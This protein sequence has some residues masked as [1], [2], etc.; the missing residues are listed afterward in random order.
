M[1]EVLSGALTVKDFCTQYAVGRSRTYELL[2]AGAILARKSGKSTLITR[3]SA[4]R[5]FGSLPAYTPPG[6]TRPQGKSP[7]RTAIPASAAK[8]APQHGA[9]QCPAPSNTVA[10]AF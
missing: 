4:E 3:A 1:N 5:W 6:L 10:T 7:I 9:A 8:V 2:A